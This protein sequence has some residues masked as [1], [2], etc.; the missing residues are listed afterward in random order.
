MND[1]LTS[2]EEVLGK[3]PSGVTPL[4]GGCIAE[5]Y[6]LDFTGG[7]RLV[8]KVSDSGG[9]EPEGWMLRYLETHSRL[10]VPALHHSDDRLLLIEYVDNDGGILGPSAQEHAAELLADLHSVTSKR[11]GL[12]RDTLIGSLTQPNRESS[13]WVE[14]F[15]DRRLNYM[16]RRALDAGT[17]SPSTFGRLENLCSRLDEWIIEPREASLLHGDVWGGNILGSGG[18][19]AAF[20]DPAIYYG[21]V[22][23][24]LAFSTL[25]STFGEPFFRRYSQLRP[26]AEGFFEQRRDLYNLYPLLV[27]TV[28]FGS[29]YA[30]AVDATLR[31][32]VA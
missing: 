19:I 26:L 17:L 14:F 24:E 25:F 28:L 16:G 9:L 20:V 29:S 22:E 1:L 13:S 23:I 6:R 12:E 10:P 30:A 31:R 32:F 27:H 3:R 4:A 5:V 2:V 21:D 15:R 8:A 11:H 18:R 7:E